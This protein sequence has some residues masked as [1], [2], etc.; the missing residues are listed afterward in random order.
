METGGRELPVP[1]GERR[2]KV[3]PRSGKKNF[4]ERACRPGAKP[5]GRARRPCEEGGG[6]KERRALRRRTRWALL[7]LGIFVLA[8]GLSLL[9]E[10]PRAVYSHAVIV[11]LDC[12]GLV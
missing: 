3:S 12:I 10:G 8:I 2:G 5:P 11:C 7:M 1:C 6:M 9:W 4:R